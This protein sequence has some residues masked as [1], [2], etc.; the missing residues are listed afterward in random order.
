MWHTSHAKFDEFSE[1]HSSKSALPYSIEL[2]KLEKML[3]IL[4]YAMFLLPFITLLH[5]KTIVLD[6]H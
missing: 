4:A 2:T 6:S 3:L 5:F 1:T